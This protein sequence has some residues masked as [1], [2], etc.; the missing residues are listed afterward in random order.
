MLFDI[1]RVLCSEA[2]IRCRVLGGGF[3]Q[4]NSVFSPAAEVGNPV[5]LDKVYFLFLFG[6]YAITSRWVWS[7]LPFGQLKIFKMAA[8]KWGRL[9]MEMFISGRKHETSYFGL[10]ECGVFKIYGKN[11]VHFMT[12]HLNVHLNI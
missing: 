2:W 3:W 1:D 12:S 5:S 10:L 11:I 8:A 4:L 7:F 9:V 6:I